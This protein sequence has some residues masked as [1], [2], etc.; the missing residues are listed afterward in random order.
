MTIAY[1]ARRS[2]LADFLRRRREALSPQEAGIP[3]LDRRRTPGLRRDEVAERA[4]MSVVYYERLERGR[5]PVPSPAM[6]SGIAK[7]LRLSAE[8]SD[9]MYSLVGQQAPVEDKPRGFIDQSLLA[10]MDAVAPTV[11]AV[12]TDEFATVLA[13]NAMSVELLGPMAGVEGPGSNMLW[14]WFTEPRW[15]DWL[16]P[17]ADHDATSRYFVAELRATLARRCEDTDAL[18]FL[19]RLMAVSEEF[20]EKW[21]DHEVASEGCACKRIEHPRVGRI[22]LEVTMV[23]SSA[24]S[25]RLVVMQP[26]RDDRD[27]LD[28]LARLHDLIA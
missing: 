11:V 28:R 1:E 20:R 10:T 13:E 24:S 14:R 18:A 12:V 23:L 17:G 21:A 27:S 19:K 16:E 8:E 5:G 6:L 2:Q 26:R 7:A 9:Y 22:E 25:Q 4:N 15:R 3:V